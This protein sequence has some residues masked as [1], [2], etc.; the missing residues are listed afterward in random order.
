MRDDEINESLKELS[1]QITVLKDCYVTLHNQLIRRE[2]NIDE[3]VDGEVKKMLHDIILTFNSFKKET[4]QAKNVITDFVKEV[5]LDLLKKQV[6][7]IR[8]E[9]RNT[10]KFLG[11]RI[12]G[13]ENII[14]RFICEQEPEKSIITNF[15]LLCMDKINGKEKFAIIKRFGE[16]LNELNSY[17]KIGKEN[18]L[19]SN[20][21]NVTVKTALKKI[22]NQ[23]NEDDIMEFPNCMFK[24]ELL[25]YCRLPNLNIGS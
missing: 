11:S 3:I 17:T 16:N 13:M 10:H 8:D 4:N 2:V 1:R 24:E 15:E 23:T 14:K 19:S 5:N 18:K 21:V 6:E 9:M 22:A 25:T 20:R 7:D 12:C